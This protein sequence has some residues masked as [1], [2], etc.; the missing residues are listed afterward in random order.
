MTNIG[1]IMVTCFL[2]FVL[3]TSIHIMDKRLSASIGLYDDSGGR[4]FSKKRT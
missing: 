1:T 3:G 4:V 2:L